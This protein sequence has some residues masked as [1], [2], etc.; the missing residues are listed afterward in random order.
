MRKFTVEQA[1]VA[2]GGVLHG[3][4]AKEIKKVV[5]DSRQTEEGTLF[6][7]ILGERVDG[8]DYIESA[9]S[10][11]ACAVI[12]ERDGF[13][14]MGGAVIR[15]NNTTEAIGKIAKAYKELCKVPTVGITGSVGKTTTK[16]MVAAV[17]SC[18]G[19]CLKTEGNFNNELGLPLTV[20]RLSESHK[21]QVLE[22][23]MSEFGEI[24]YLAD[25]ARPDV[26]VITNIG[27]SHIENLGSREGILKAKCEI[28]D[29]FSEENVLII[30]ND[31]DMLN[32]LS[33]DAV[34]KTITYGI[35]KESDY[36]AKDIKDM[37]IDGSSFTAVTPAGEVS[38]KLSVA[39]VHNVYNALAA[40]AVGY[41]FGIMPE[42]ASEKLAD[43]KLTA[44]RMSIEKLKG[45]TIINDCYNAAPDSVSA[46][47]DVLKKSEGRRVA[48]LGDMFELGDFS[49]EAH[50]KVGEKCSECA[51]VVI[52]AGDMARNI[53]RETLKKG[54]KTEYYSTNEEAAVAAGRIVKEGD[55]VL[56]KASRGMHFEVVYEE[57][58]KILL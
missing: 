34:Y 33:K 56:I 57:I 53:A 14:N 24:H 54:I 1:A 2:C 29:F 49:E 55:T 17:M 51:D 26:G 12:S 23:G 11:G 15:V 41:S 27:L 37:G 21:S 45:V 52:C 3:D 48:V 32:T 47:L 36:M 58:K 28:A 16:D 7:A 9:F 13:E 42:A 35:E 50:I 43:F 44:M 39:G 6:A 31:N 30:N 40:M 5:I 46:S 38:V 4:G 18:L 10:K 22:M 8:H 25:I 20:F 19:D